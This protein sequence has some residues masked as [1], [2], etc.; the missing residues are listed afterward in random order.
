MGLV[1]SPEKMIERWPGIA[2]RLI[3]ELR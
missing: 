3:A 2:D 1:K